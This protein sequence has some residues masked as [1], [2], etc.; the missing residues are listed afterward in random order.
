[1]G[2]FTSEFG[3]FETCQLSRAMSAFDRQRLPNR[4]SAR[5]KPRQYATMATIRGRME[6]FETVSVE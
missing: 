3:T 5:E 1:M 2:V 6:P 4:L